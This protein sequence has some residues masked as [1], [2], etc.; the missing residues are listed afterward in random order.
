[1]TQARTHAQKSEWKRVRS[2]TASCKGGVRVVVVVVVMMMVVVMML[3]LHLYPHYIPA[4][5]DDVPALGHT[6]VMGG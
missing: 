6:Q 4:Y 3:M 1:M 2:W 5:A